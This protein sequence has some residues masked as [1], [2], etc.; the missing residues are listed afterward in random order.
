MDARPVCP[1]CGASLFPRKE[2]EFGCTQHGTWYPAAALDAALG[3]GTSTT[4]RDRA[5]KGATVGRKCPN[6][7]LALAAY[8]SPSGRVRVEG[9]GRCGGV[10]LA[11]PVLDEVSR[12]TPTPA[13]AAGAEARAILGWAA[14]RGAVLRPPPGAAPAR[15][16]ARPT[17]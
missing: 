7:R 10:W 12:S 8:T 17:R 5:E 15:G 14:V 4:A 11:T 16:A 13:G 3:P 9:C 1:M 6:D 2:G